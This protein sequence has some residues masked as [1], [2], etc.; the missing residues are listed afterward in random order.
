M[1]PLSHATLGS[2]ECNQ[3]WTPGVTLK[4]ML[5]WLHHA[6]PECLLCSGHQA[7]VSSSPHSRGLCPLGGHHCVQLLVGVPPGTESRVGHPGSLCGPQNWTSA[8]LILTGSIYG[9]PPGSLHRAG[10]KTPLS[11]AGAG[12]GGKKR[13]EQ[14]VGCGARGPSC[15]GQAESVSGGETEAWRTGIAPAHPAGLH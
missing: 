7:G 2:W 8:L 12:A 10:H 13:E 4:P 14:G 9:V 15:P 1:T 11:Q 3:D 5:F 6:V